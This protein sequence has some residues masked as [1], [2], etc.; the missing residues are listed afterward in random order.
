M[1]ENRIE[2]AV[3]GRPGGLPDAAAL[4]DERLLEALV[5]GAGWV[6]V[7]EM[8]LSENPSPVARLGKDLGDGPLVGVEQVFCAVNPGDARAKGPTARQEACPRRRAIRIHVE[9][10]EL[11]ALPRQFV[12]VWGVEDVVSVHS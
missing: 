3:P 7:P 4:V 10:T 11:G 6:I 1:D 12:E 9:A 2:V 5:G 8:P